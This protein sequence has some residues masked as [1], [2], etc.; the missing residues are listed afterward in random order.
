MIYKYYGMHKY[1]LWVLSLLPLV[2]LK[3]SQECIVS[4]A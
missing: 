1:N 3:V 4:G 2:N